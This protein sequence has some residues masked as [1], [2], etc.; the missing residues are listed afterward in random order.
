MYVYCILVTIMF[1]PTTRTVRRYFIY[2]E[3]SALSPEQIYIYYDE[4]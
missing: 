4:G 1:N 2:A 3:P